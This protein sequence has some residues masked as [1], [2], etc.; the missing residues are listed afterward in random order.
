MTKIFTTGTISNKGLLNLCLWAGKALH[1]KTLYVTQSGETTL[2]RKN[3]TS[4]TLTMTS[5]AN[6]VSMYLQMWKSFG[7]ASIK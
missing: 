4:P 5:V 6:S 3:F 7:Y 2:C 1:K